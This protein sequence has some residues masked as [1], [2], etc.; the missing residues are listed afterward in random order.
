MGASPAW[1]ATSSVRSGSVQLSWYSPCA[2]SRNKYTRQ[3]GNR[4]LFEGLLP[5]PKRMEATTL[6]FRL[7][8]R[9]GMRRLIYRLGL[10]RLLPGRLRDLE[11]MLPHLPQRPLRRVLPEL[12]PASGQ[13]KYRIG[14]FLGCAQ[15]LLFAE[16]SAAT[17]RVLVRNDCSVIT[18]KEVECCGMPAHGYGRLDL[19][20]AQARH[21]IA[22][23]EKTGVE[24]IITDCATC[25][26]TLKDYGKLL[27]GEPGW[28][29][30]AAAFSTRIRDISEFLAEIPL[31]KPKGRIEKRVTYHD[32]CHLRRAQ[33]V[34]K[35]PRHLLGLID[36]L[37]YVE[38]P[39]ADWCCGS[40][41]SQLI[42]HYETSLK[43]MDRKLDNLAST[44]AQVVAS[45]CPGCQMQLI[46]AVKRRGL[47]VQVV[48]PI[49]LL[50]QA[51]GTDHGK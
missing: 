11:A 6:P 14:F 47:G 38:L 12:V 24:T 44:A 25:G 28:A 19:V 4:T 35:Q 29:E 33:K 9:S 20:R 16:E 17:V 10:S 15:S 22:V 43:V 45:G 26:S 5:H 46:T 42:T 37:D 31:E 2:T 50:D 32:P 7:Y 21:N 27:E 30:R 40:A 23:F 3:V 13:E 49:S 48:H 36:G 18:P 51:Y 41:G 34:W 39:E 1:P 8:E